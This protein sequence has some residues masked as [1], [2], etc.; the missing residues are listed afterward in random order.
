MLMHDLVCQICKKI[1]SRQISPLQINNGRGKYCSKQCAVKGTGNLR[2]CDNSGS[3]HYLWKGDDVGYMGVHAW[4]RKRLPKP[5]LCQDC[6]LVPPR[7]LANISQE[8]KR[9]LSDW[10]YLCRKCHM[11]KD[12]RLERAAKTQFRKGSKPWNT[13]L[14]TGIVPRS[15]FKKG[16]T[17]WN[18]GKKNVLA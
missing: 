13:G 10:E 7:D 2:K 4:V 18:K 6:L 8:Y 3:N 5:L 16:I 12:G 14:K 1:F 17:P 15:A 9:D 11:T